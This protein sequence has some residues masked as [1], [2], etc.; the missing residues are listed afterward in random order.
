MDRQEFSSRLHDALANIHDYVVLEKNVLNEII[1]RADP[2]IRKA[3]NLRKFIWDGINTLKP[4]DSEDHPDSL[5]NRYYRILSGRYIQGLAVTELQKR[6]ALGERQ[7]RRMHS[8]A[9]DALEELLWDRLVSDSRV[10][11][12]SQ[13]E[14]ASHNPISRPELTLPENFGEDLSFPVALESLHLRKVIE[15]I[16]TLFHPQF[17]SRGGL[18]IQVPIDLPMIQA[19]RVILRQILL[20]IFNHILQNH[21]GD[22]VTIDASL[23]AG[24]IRLRIDALEKQTGIPDDQDFSSDRLFTYWVERLD[25]R[26]VTED[27]SSSEGISSDSE[28]SNQIAYL[29]DLPMAD[30]VKILVVDDHEPAIRIIQRCLSQTNIQ[31]IGVTDPAQVLIMAR[32]IHPKAVLLDVML[33]GIDGWEILQKL[34]SDPGTSQIPIIIC[35]VWDQPDLAYSLGADAFLKK[36]IIQSE[37]VSELVRLNLLDSAGE[38]PPINF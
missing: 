11:D 38:Q 15:E 32:S 31:T 17:Q 33:P 8:R 22:E 24:N 12:L 9:V 4:P 14:A 7:E 23:Y 21:A 18:S 6:L 35:S 5:E 27:T 16:A 37:L 36:P 30:Q 19:D 29:L 1:P 28:H 25:A 3:D 20:H 13:Q 10:R 34:K 26:F 2:S